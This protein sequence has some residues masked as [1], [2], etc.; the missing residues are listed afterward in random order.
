LTAPAGCRRTTE[1]T[2]C[3]AVRFAGRRAML[4]DALM[5]AL[6]GGFVFLMIWAKS[7]EDDE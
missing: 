4:H 6:G 7:H 2:A 3:G 5:F 1:K